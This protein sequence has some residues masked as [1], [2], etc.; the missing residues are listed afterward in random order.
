MSSSSSFEIVEHSNNRRLKDGRK[1]DKKIPMTS[2]DRSFQANGLLPNI[3][4]HISNTQTVTIQ[5]M[6]AV[7]AWF[8]TSTTVNTSTAT[9]FQISNTPSFSSMSAVWDQYRIDLLEFWLLPR[10]QIIDTNGVNPGQIVS[11]IDLDDNSNVAFPALSGYQSA[12]V[13]SGTVGHYHRWQP[14]AA[15]AAYSS[16]FSSF[17]NV[18]SP[19]IDCANGNVQHYGCKIAATPSTNIMVFDYNVRFTV[20]YRGVHD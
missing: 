19:W 8:S 7:Q 6:F 17:A 2:M 9:Y 13:T 12:I 20:T 4:N 10:Q 14:H 11:A 18:K 16:T 15:I 3:K 1:N 5:S